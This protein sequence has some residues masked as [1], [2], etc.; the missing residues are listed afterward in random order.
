M[1][2]HPAGVK[3]A[4]RKY[5]LAEIYARLRQAAAAGQ[6]REAVELLRLALPIDLGVP[7]ASAIAAALGQQL[8][9]ALTYRG[10]KPAE[11]AMLA[12]DVKPVLKLED[13][14][15]D[16][17]ARF[18]VRFA[19]AYQIH[20]S[21]PYTKD[22]LLLR[23][24]PAQPGDPHAL[25]SLYASRND[26]GARLQALEE[27]EREAVEACGALLGFPACCA[28]AF[29]DDFR[30]SRQDQDTVNDD[31]TRRLVD[32]ATPLAPG[33]A[34]LNPLSDL[35]TIGCYACSP[36]CTHAVALA[37]RSVAALYQRRPELLATMRTALTAPTLLWRVP[38][39]LVFDGEP[40]DDGVAYRQVA[41]N[42]F[43]DARVRRVQALFAAALVPLL[44]QGNW[45]AVR[46][47]HIEVRRD[48][49]HVLD[50]GLTGTPPALSCWEWPADAPE[51]NFDPQG[52]A[53]QHTL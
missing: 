11:L 29:A 37:R 48:G 45:L 8:R 51:N 12:A 7:D 47:D 19:D 4:L 6:V 43:A 30:V 22:Y 20:R 26:D 40:A 31:A 36:H 16:E 39:F 50:V 38:F 13:I 2:R 17:A 52:P 24:H 9:P 41:A 23:S 49:Q 25:V 18:E 28:Q 14:P 44:N 32:R 42:G 1:L 5:Q 3:G 35:E 34:W 10:F 21:E 15:L 53:G 46:R 33:H 27:K